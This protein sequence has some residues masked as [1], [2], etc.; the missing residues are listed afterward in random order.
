MIAVDFDLGEHRERHI[1]A[2][3]AKRLDLLRIARLL[4]TE[5]VAG[6]AQHHQPLVTLILPKVLQPLVLGGKTAFGGDIDDQQGFSA[7][8]AERALVAVDIADCEIVDAGH[9]ASSCWW[10]NSAESTPSMMTLVT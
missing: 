6:K 2:G 1:V 3:A 7:P 8:F 5:L 9:K 4:M 10:G